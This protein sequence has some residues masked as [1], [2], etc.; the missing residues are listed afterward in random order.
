MSKI[1][2]I[3]K[4]AILCIKHP[5][6]LLKGMRYLLNHGPS[7][8]IKNM[9][10]RASDRRVLVDEPIKFS[11]VM[12]V[13]KVE[14]KW[15]DKAIKS[16]EQQT[17]K[18]W[19]LC[20]ADDFSQDD[21]IKEYLNSKIS[22]KIKVLYLEE[23]K[24]ISIASNAAAGL[25]TGEYILLMDNDDIIASTALEEFYNRIKDTNPDI[26]YSDHDIID[27]NDNHRDPL[28]KPD[29]SYDLFLCQM[30]LGHLLGFKK[31]LFFMVNGFDSKFNGAQD[32]DLV[33]RMI[34][35]TQKI[36]HVSK[37]LYS[38]RAIPSST[39]INPGSKPYA[40]TAG[41]LALANHL[42][43]TL[44]QDK[45]DVWESENLFVYDVRY[46]LNYEPLVSIIIPIKDQID[47]LDTALKS[48]FSKTSYKNYEI[49]IVNNCSEE[50]DTYNYLEKIQMEHHNVNVVK[51][52]CEFNWSKL[53]NIG[54]ENANGE[55]FVFLNNDIEVISEDWLTRLVENAI[56]EDVGVVG[57]L[58][59]YDD[60]T[61][62]HAGIVIGIGGWADHI[63]KGMAPIHYGTP[64][65]SPM[66]TR[67]V[68][69]VTGACM[70]ISRKTMEKIG[71]FD[72]SFLICGS[73]VEI[74]VKASKNGL[75]NIYLPQ[76]KLYH[77]ESKSRDNYIPDIDFKKSYELYE[78]YRL[79]GD[80][81]Y[82]SQL[83][84]NETTPTIDYA[85]LPE[86]QPNV[87]PENTIQESSSIALPQ[88]DYVIPEITPYT[89]R[90]GTY[91]NKRLNLLVPSINTEHVF[92]GI[93]TAIKFFDELA[94]VTGYDMRMILT[95]ATP[96]EEAIK[97]YSESRGYTFVD[98]EKDSVEKKQI[99]SYCDR[100]M[101][102]IPVSEN[103][104]FIFTGWW[105]A[106]CCQEAYES[107]VYKPNIFLYF[108]QDYEPGF[109]PWSSRY[110]LADAS[111]KNKLPHIAIFN[112][113][114]LYDYFK[115]NGYN[116]TY[117]FVFEPSLNKS[118][119]EIL[120]NNLGI[121][122]KRK[123]IL[124]YGRPSVDR[125]AFSL[126]IYILKKWVSIYPDSVDWVVLS[127]GELHETIE[128][129]NGVVLK[130][131]G[132]LSIEEYGKVLLETYAGISLMESPH[133]SYPPLE[134]STF[135]AKVITNTYKNKDL[136]KFN[137]NIISLSNVSP[138]VV[139]K[140]LKKI[141][142][143][144]EEKQCLKI[145]NN[146]YI[147]TENIFDF[148]NEISELLK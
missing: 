35:V 39:A 43:R 127:A 20:I 113:K 32:Y 88:V 70:C 80:P 12:P 85:K 30:Y 11:I 101:K 112:T 131:V 38:W 117:E 105:T 124:V 22:E 104:Y 81:F 143:D 91:P 73:D 1:K 52:Y 148:L 27:E 145:V 78:P 147:N 53:N 44:G 56:R 136:S 79:K 9:K 77:F 128:L 62:Q 96:N 4:L 15:L 102:S 21:A 138:I 95:D 42:D 24:G 123:Q 137:E 36:E 33:L 60:D 93:S 63:F 90:K 23:N 58:L 146:D 110:M 8:F 25:A 7:A 34:E 84:Y 59:L 46:R 126:L 107:F 115:L 47:L 2:K 61:I 135:G 83:N 72:E 76:I 74:C 19:E 67:N 86:Y 26:I 132:K 75:R 94:D 133:P 54:I 92:G 122:K 118:L 130:S 40:Q 50:L 129:G 141:C 68:S 69:A 111:Y 71:L 18:N 87:A 17:Y 31:D 37:V 16:V 116:F 142:E 55:V 45:A 144:Y 28:L 134:M 5:K 13:Y 82:N 108:I 120:D 121:I 89:F 3:A 57:P 106:H 49:I 100:Y 103:D 114:L 10:S 48:I 66:V 139:A 125:N 65:L 51:G 98:C 97:I 109:Y 119:K 6:T 140:I 64:F 99:V 29:W 41:Q 14:I